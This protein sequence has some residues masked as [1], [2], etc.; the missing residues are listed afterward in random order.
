MKRARRVEKT[1]L[2]WSPEAEE[3][4]CEGCGSMIR[5][6]FGFKRCPYCRR[7]IV[8]AAQRRARTGTGAGCGV[9]LK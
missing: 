4:V 6:N 8:S 3:L 7:E 1:R 9:I 5:W 2:V